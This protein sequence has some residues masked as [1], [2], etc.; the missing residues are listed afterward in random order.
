MATVTGVCCR[1]VSIQTSPVAVSPSFFLCLQLLLTGASSLP[2]PSFSLLVRPLSSSTCL[3]FAYLVS[4]SF[5]GGISSDEVL[6]LMWSMMIW[7]F[8]FHGWEQSSSTCIDRKEKPPC[9]PPG[10]RSEPLFFFF[11]SFFFCG[12]FFLSLGSCLVWMADVHS[13]GGLGCEVLCGSSLAPFSWL[14]PY[15]ILEAISALPY[16]PLRESCLVVLVLSFLAGAVDSINLYFWKL[17]R[18]VIR[19]KLLV[20][21][22]TAGFVVLFSCLV[23]FVLFIW[24]EDQV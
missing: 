5:F 3:L 1:T 20:S 9:R 7:I 6:R 12:V 13:H 19:F 18:L 24:V 10:Q 2:P 16:H 4:G 23:L 21:V 22:H 8:L 11:L 15:P 14:W 17:V